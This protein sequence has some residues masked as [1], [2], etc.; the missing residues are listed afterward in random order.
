MSLLD[1]ELNG[2]KFC[3]MNAKTL[4]LEKI[5]HKY[6]G[7]FR[8]NDFRTVKHVL[9]AEIFRTN[10]CNILTL[11]HIPFCF[12]FRFVYLFEKYIAH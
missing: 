4:I 11:T 2:G 5:K 7:H 9:H 1:W 3:C 12:G 10:F 6:E 8:K